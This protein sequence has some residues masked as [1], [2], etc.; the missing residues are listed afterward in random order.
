MF[1]V[2]LNQISPYKKK[3]LQTPFQPSGGPLTSDGNPGL[4]NR[5][6][7]KTSRGLTVNKEGF[8]T[9]LGTSYIS[10]PVLG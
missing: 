2:I 5:F 6:K 8:L 10:V 9:G 1:S 7:K 4:V 3:I